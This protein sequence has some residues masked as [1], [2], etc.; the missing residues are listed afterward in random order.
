MGVTED[1]K[2]F[3]IE[4]PKYNDIRQEILTNLTDIFPH[5]QQETPNG[6]FAFLMQCHD[7]EATQLFSLMVEKMALERGSL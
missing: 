2:H 3:I 7:Y 6:Q 4:C 1:E 5:V